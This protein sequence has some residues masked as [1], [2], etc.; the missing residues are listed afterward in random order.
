MNNVTL[1]TTVVSAARQHNKYVIFTSSSEVY[2]EGPFREDASLSIGSPDNLR[3]GYASAKLTTEFLVASSGCRYKILRLFNIT[4]PGQAS[5]EYGMVLP[6]FVA[7]AL[8]GDDIV[9]HG[10]GAQVRSFCHIDDAVSMFRAIELLP[11]NGIF[12]VGND[13]TVSILPLAELVLAAIPQTTSKLKR[14][15]DYIKASGDITSRVPD[16]TK[17]RKHGVYVCTK[18]IN[19]IIRDTINDQLTHKLR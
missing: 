7:A 14:D 9:V 2:G 5:D 11:Q 19:D 4:G 16:W 18:D 8:A 13:N 6:R 12:N 17:I 10:S 1:A 15:G 3:W